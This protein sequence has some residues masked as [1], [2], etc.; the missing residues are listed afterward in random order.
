MG[1]LEW[2]LVVFSGIGLVLAA[3]T[4]AAVLSSDKED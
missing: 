4:I 2:G 3:F 1:I